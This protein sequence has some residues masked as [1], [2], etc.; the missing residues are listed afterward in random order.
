MQSNRLR[1]LRATFSQTCKYK[2]IRNA[3]SLA[4]FAPRVPISPLNLDTP[5]D[6][7]RQIAQLETVKSGS[8]RPLTL[9]EKIL[10]S[11]LYTSPEHSWALDEIRRGE[12]LLHLRPDRVACHDATATMALLQFISAGLPKVQIPTTVHSDHLVVSRDGAEEDLKRGRHEHR[13]VYAFLSSAAKKYGIGWWKPGAGIIHTTIFENYAFPGGLIIGTD[14]HTPNAG[15]MGM[16]GI[17]VGGSDAVDAMAG[18]PW[19]LMCPKVVGVRLTGSLN[20]WASTKDIICKLAGILT[21]SGGKGRVIEFFGPGTQ[22]LGA[23]AMAT[24]CNM[25]AEIGSTSCIFPYSESMSRYLTATKRADIA[26]LASGYKDVLLTADEGSE[27]H[28][29]EVIEIDLDTLEP[30][31]NGPFTPDLSHPLS[32]LKEAVSKSDWPVEVSHAMVGSCTNSSYE[33]LLKTSQLIQ[34]AHS[35][36]LPHVK[37][38]FMVSPGSEDIR[39]TAEAEGILQTI[40]DAGAVV[41]STTCGPCVGQWD[42]T[43]V[44]VKGRERNTVVSSFNR[45]FVARHDG[46]PE[47]CSFVTSPEMVTAFAYAGRIDFNPVTDS[48]PVA[49]SSQELR[50]TAP[51]SVE[52]PTAFTTGED[53]YQAPVQNASHLSV[54]IDPKSDRLQLL[55]PFQPWVPGST[56]SMPILVKVKGKC[57]TDHISPAGPWYK[58]RGHLENISNNMLLAASNAFLPSDSKHLGHTIHPLDS[59]VDLIHEVARDLRGRG[60]KWCIIGDWNYGEGS[61]R[62]HAALEPRFLGGVAVI[63]RSFAR[64]H[65]TNLKKQG[66]LPLTFV[67][68]GDYDRIRSGDRVTLLG[69]EEGEMKP[70]KEVTL[71][72]ETEAGEVWRAALQHSF[73]EGQ[74]RWLRAG[75]ALNHIKQT[76]L[77]NQGS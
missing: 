64:I 43:D 37:T 36:G 74:L 71:Q 59:H 19:E 55:D 12:T 17:G 70:G 53:L 50:F 42:R 31:I 26:R 51:T 49:G 65:E 54:T 75:S 58:Y 16:L 7:D 40:R 30:H 33:D 15:G 52:L 72:V 62:E 56:N 44:D 48:I 6:Y 4:T 28:Y 67:E 41:L 38:S 39:A 13:E 77:G 76:I 22:T 10:Y 60:V 61:S 5:L 34:Q 24:V 25:S 73:S 1:A 68:A 14:S 69:V 2:S 18:M 46:N 21:V 45:N 3:R 47:T 35:A 63:A 8:R 29:D 23:T 11:H 32:Q 20:G 27:N 57:T 66:M 9:T